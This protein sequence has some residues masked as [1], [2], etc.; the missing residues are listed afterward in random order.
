MKWVTY[1]CD[2]KHDDTPFLALKLG[3]DFWWTIGL[4]QPEYEY[5]KCVDIL[6]L[7]DAKQHW[8][9]MGYKLVPE[10]VGVI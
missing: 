10:E 3:S 6:S 5:L 9:N 7:S 8:E 2:E 4:E 1:I